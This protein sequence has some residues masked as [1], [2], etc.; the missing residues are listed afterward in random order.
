[1]RPGRLI[2]CLSAF[3]A[4]HE[5]NYTTRHIGEAPETGNEKPPTR[6]F[7]GQVLIVST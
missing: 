5:S 4:F 7:A 3:A 1:M 2:R 6:A